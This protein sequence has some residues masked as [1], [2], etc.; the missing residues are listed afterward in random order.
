MLERDLTETN[1]A[2]AALMR[3]KLG[4]RRGSTL[5]AKLRIAGRL[6]PK[7]ERKAGRTL[8]EAERLWAN[9]KLRRRLDPAALAAAE[10]RLRGFLDR[11]DPA[12]RRKGMILGILASLAFNFLLIAA[13]AIVWACHTGRI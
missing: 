10:A 8:V 5:A 1:A 3:E 12:D 4:I 7:A 9:P 6:L 2:L 11:I 13:A